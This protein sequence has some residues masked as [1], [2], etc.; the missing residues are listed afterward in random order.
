MADGMADAGSRKGPS[1]ASPEA[2]PLP[3]SAPKY[4]VLQQI[5]VETIRNELRPRDA[6]PSERQLMARF[7]VSRATVRAAIAE[8]AQEG[9]LERIHGKGTFVAE[10]RVVSRLH[11][12]SFSEDMRRRGLEPRTE[13]L[14]ARRIAADAELARVL[15]LPVGAHCARIERLRLA[16]GTPMAHEVGVYPVD[17]LPGLLEHDLTGSIYALL[18]ETYGLAPEEG[19][20][21]LGAERTT[22]RQA[23]LLGVRIGAPVLVFTRTAGSHGMPIE[24]TVSRYRADRYLVRME[25]GPA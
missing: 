24:H 6:I 9:H 7:G 11:L 8:L 17:R 14:E 22:R 23:A 5:L 1:A 13:V 2:R 25:L 20:Q 4:R 15:E 10:R 16:D 21:L 18:R 19:E 12:A 3:A